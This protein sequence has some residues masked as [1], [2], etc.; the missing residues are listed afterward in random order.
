LEAIS[1]PQYAFVHGMQILDEILIAKEIVDEA[2][3]LKK[4]LLLFKVDL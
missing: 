1:E 3:R 4:E 2:R